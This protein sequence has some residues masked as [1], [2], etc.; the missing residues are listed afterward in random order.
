MNFSELEQKMSQV[1]INSL[2][3]IARHL[4]TTPQAVSNW[5][6][7]NQV[8]YH[9][10]AK[11]FNHDD[12]ETHSGNQ[13]NLIQ[14]NIEYTPGINLA[15]ILIAISEQ[16]KII[17]LITFISVFSTLTYV[18]FM[19]DSIFVSS[20][21]L[22]LPENKTSQMGSLA[23][24]ASQFGVNVPSS[25]NADLSN[26]SLYPELIKSNT[27]AEK[28]MD[29]EFYLKKYNKKL[30]L[31][32]ILADGNKALGN[33]RDLL[34]KNAI[35]KLNSEILSFYNE[36]LRSP[37]SIL[38]VSTNDALFSKELADVVLIEL[39][40]L[41]REFKKN[42]VDEKILFINN[43]ILSVKNDLSISEI[44]LK[45]FNEK[46][47]QISSP[48]L[49]LEQDRLK[50][51]LDVQKDIY[52]TLKQQL[53]LAKIEEI[54]QVS[55][56]QILDKP[57]VSLVRSNNNK[58]RT[59]FASL[60]LGLIFGTLIGLLRSFFLYA[61]IDQR[62]KYRKIRYFLNKKGKELFNDT[63]LSGSALIILLLSSPIYFFSNSEQPL[64]FNRYS[65]GHMLI[66][67]FIFLTSL[68]CLVIYVHGRKKNSQ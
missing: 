64:Y 56:V 46:N 31:I 27:F 24:L 47:R 15:D 49:A 63:R 5:K 40:L 19:V 38:S 13:Q 8:P 7:R 59:L 50:R 42:S 30:P 33:N 4:E 48:A 41:N 44:K 35:S 21:T 43:R 51:D 9:V 39:D 37:L 55:V 12:S 3:E 68:I 18:Q 65:Q 58:V 29:K 25:S 6:S 54:E 57:K 61:N 1:G 32:D 16:L 26:P 36:P 2:A 20:A 60:I 52:L 34:L 14:K 23:G 17:I 45:N 22:L 28:I 10:V 11:V 66:N 53:E 62:K 67:I